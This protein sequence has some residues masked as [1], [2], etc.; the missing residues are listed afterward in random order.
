MKG[1][2]I[3]V[4][5]LV[6]G[7]LLIGHASSE[8]AVRVESMLDEHK[9]RTVHVDHPGAHVHW[10]TDHLEVYVAGTVRSYDAKEAQQL[11]ISAPNVTV[12]LEAGIV[13]HG[14]ASAGPAIAA[15][16]TAVGLRVTGGTDGAK[17]VIRGYAGAIHGPRVAG[18]TVSH[19]SVDRCNGPGIVLGDDAMVEDIQVRHV[20]GDG[21]VLGRLSRAERIVIRSTHGLGIALGER[22]YVGSSDVSGHASEGIVVGAGGMVIESRASNGGTGIVLGR[23]SLARSVVAVSNVGD[24]ITTS[25]SCVVTGSVAEMNGGTGIVVNDGS[26]VESSVANDNGDD[27]VVSGKGCVLRGLA[28]RTNV[29]TGFVVGSGSSVIDSV[30]SNGFIGIR[31]LSGDIVLDGVTSHGNA[32]GIAAPTAFESSVNLSQNTEGA[33]LPAGS[34]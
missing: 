9:S 11:A 10:R 12:F 3:I 22:G 32:Y 13:L 28:A 8:E 33:Y 5:C 25:Y 30:A 19:L 4:A 2:A 6:L 24:G 27:G 29:H 1:T 14:R 31:A 15:S 34:M 21:V 7:V 20:S 23:G 17:P 26:V 18:A 16:A